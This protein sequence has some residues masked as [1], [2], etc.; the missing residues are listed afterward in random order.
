MSDAMAFTKR[1]GGFAPTERFRAAINENFADGA[2]YWLTVEPQR[3][4]K[5][6]GHEFA[7]V[8]EAWKTLP[9]HLTAEY[10]SSEHL[11]KKA[12]IATGWHTVQDYV[13]TSRAEAARWAENLRREADKYAVIVVSGT[14]VRVFKAR[15]QAKAAM[16][17]ADFQ[18]SKTHI[19]DWIAHLIGV[20]PEDLLQARAA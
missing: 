18:A 11:R 20:A 8:T 6:H 15:S 1:P 12:L 13:C 17:A 2:V 14:V 19:L 5:S 16:G 4:E 10:P 9:D 7:W 3:S